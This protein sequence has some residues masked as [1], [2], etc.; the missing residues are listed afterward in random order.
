M[1]VDEIRRH[2]RTVVLEYGA[3]LGL[4]KP[5]P[6]GTYWRCEHGVPDN[7][8]VVEVYAITMGEFIKIVIYSPDFEPVET[9]RGAMPLEIFPSYVNIRD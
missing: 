1:I 2:C 6:G 4:L 3:L 7:A 8:E 5:T 9:P